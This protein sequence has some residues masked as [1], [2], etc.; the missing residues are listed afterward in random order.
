MPGMHMS[1]NKEYFEA[2]GRARFAPSLIVMLGIE[3]CP[4]LNILA[5]QA[6]LA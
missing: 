3:C 5:V 2:L 1:L 6:K 4:F